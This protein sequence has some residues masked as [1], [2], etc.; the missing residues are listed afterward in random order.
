MATT[1]RTSVTAP[2]SPAASR[3][4]APAHPGT[5]QGTKGLPQ[6]HKFNIDLTDVLSIRMTFSSPEPPGRVARMA[7]LSSGPVV[8]V[9]HPSVSIEIET[10]D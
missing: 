4:R 7:A 9:P 10:L 2:R 1:R 5:P 3:K 6:V 8:P